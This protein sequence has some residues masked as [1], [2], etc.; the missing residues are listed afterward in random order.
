V[1]DRAPRPGRT[2]NATLSAREREVLACIME[3]LHDREIAD[4]LSISPRTVQ[5]HVLAILNKLGARSRPEA[6]AIALRSNLL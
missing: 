4:R 6:V 2:S 1:L 3:G 5:S